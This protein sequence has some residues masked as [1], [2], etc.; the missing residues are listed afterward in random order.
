MC[1]VCYVFEF[2]L[3]GW[4]IWF[5]L[6]M[7][8]IKSKY[9]TKSCFMVLSVILWSDDLEAIFH[10][11]RNVVIILLRDLSLLYKGGL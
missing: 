7:C 10:G 6:I 9:G 11:E 2:W 1:V 3:F 5:V 8:E 4:K